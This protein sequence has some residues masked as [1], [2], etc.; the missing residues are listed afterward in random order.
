MK[1]I[2]AA[3][4]AGAATVAVLTGVPAAAHGQTSTPA[5]SSPA[6]ASAPALAAAD[7]YFYAWKAANFDN[8]AGWCRWFYDD[9][10]WQNDCANMRNVISGAWNNSNSG[11]VVRLHYNP[12]YRGA[13]ACLGPGDS[14]YDFLNQGIRFSWGSGL[15]GYWQLASDNVA[16]HRFARACA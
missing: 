1:R 13:W 12:D 2:R 15:P 4:L 8:N 16:S 5:V 3:L 6:G 11:N 7:G 10:N 14:W 9:A